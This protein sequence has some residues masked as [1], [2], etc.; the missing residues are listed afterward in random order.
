MIQCDT[1]FHPSVLFSSPVFG[2]LRKFGGYSLAC[3]LLSYTGSRHISFRAPLDLGDTGTWY[4]KKDLYI[5][6]VAFAVGL[7]CWVRRPSVVWLLATAPAHVAS[8]AP[9]Q[10]RSSH[11]NNTFYT[12]THTHTTHTLLFLRSSAGHITT[13]CWSREV[14]G[15]DGTAR[16]SFVLGTAR[17][18]VAS[19]AALSFGEL[20]WW[21]RCSGLEPSHSIAR[22]VSP[23]GPDGLPLTPHWSDES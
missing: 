4:K 23:S 12:H 10:H 18:G 21:L 3:F 8:I 22:R 2:R 11:T 19:F 16:F 6:I 1:F 20:L 5:T 9:H 7:F 14:S 15:V 17:R 13:G